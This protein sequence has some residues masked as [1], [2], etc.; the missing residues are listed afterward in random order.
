VA[1][2]DVRDGRVVYTNF[3]THE[4][5]VHSDLTI[6]RLSDNRYRVVTGGADGNRDYLW[7]R[8]CRDDLGLDAQIVDRTY[9]LS[10]IGLWGPNARRIMEQFV[11]EKNAVSNTTF[12]F[13]SAQTFDIAGVRVWAL[14]ISYVGE[15]G[16]ELYIDF[17]E[18]AQVWDAFYE[19]G[20]VPVGIE[21]YANSRRLEKS[22]R[23]QGADL[24]TEY[25]LVEA[26]LARPKLKRANFVGREAYE[27]IRNRDCQPA[28]LSTLTVDDSVDTNGVRRFIV[29]QWPIL[30]PTTRTVLTDSA[31]RRSYNTSA[32]YGPSLDAQILMGYLPAEYAQEGRSLLIEYFGEHFPVTVRRV[33]STGLYDPNNLRVKA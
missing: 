28:Y 31:G 6:T 21:T 8:N 15:L 11:G 9:Q 13:G 33:G 18:A 29:G 2:V 30:D 4:G 22:F 19:A 10:T 7:I 24:E 5:G 17:E 3:L 25:N 16:W 14:R 27:A 26:G 20:V 32:A 1:N 12:P 23:L